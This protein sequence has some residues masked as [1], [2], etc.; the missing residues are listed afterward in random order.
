MTQRVALA[1]GQVV[2]TEWS[3][4]PDYRTP[5]RVT[6]AA[7]LDNLVESEDLPLAPWY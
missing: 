7:A 3:S 2:S 1:V 5:H 6:L 4:A